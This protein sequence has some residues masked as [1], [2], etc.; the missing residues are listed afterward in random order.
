MSNESLNRRSFLKTVALRRRPLQLRGLAGGAAFGEGHVLHEVV[1][2][3]EPVAPKYS[4][5]FAVCA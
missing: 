4:I 5:K 2:A 1:A 3:Q